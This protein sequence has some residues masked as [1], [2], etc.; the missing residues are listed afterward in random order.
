EDV[1]ARYDKEIGETTPEQEVQARHILV[2]TQEEA[3]AIIAELDG[4]ADFETL[5]KEK[6]TGPSGPQG[7]DLGFFA[8]G[9]MVP[10]F[11]TAAFG[12]EDGEYT[13]EPVKTQFGFHVIQR[14]GSR[15]VALPTLEQAGEQLRQ[16]LLTERYAETVQKGREEVGVELIDKTLALPDPDA[17]ENDT[18]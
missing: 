7:G 1:K 3:D 18:N 6:S 8:K 15:D 5:A 10:E 16:F 14:V 2:K 9:R 11:E 17:D 4:G 12:M 13:K